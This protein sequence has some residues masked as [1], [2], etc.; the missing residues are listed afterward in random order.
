MLLQLVNELHAVGFRSPRGPPFEQ[1][2]ALLAD[3]AHLGAAAGAAGEFRDGFDD[4]EIVVAKRHGK[5]GG[6]KLGAIR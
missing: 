2:L 1:E 4:A 6:F 5:L 3:D